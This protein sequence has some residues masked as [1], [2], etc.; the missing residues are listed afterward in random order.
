MVL[1]TPE[2]LHQHTYS[3]HRLSIAFLYMHVIY[4]AVITQKTHTSQGSYASSVV[5]PSGIRIT[6]R[7][8]LTGGHNLGFLLVPLSVHTVSL[9]SIEGDSAEIRL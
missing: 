7:G 9:Q 5:F 3:N 1:S 6:R 2:Y 8:H 4:F